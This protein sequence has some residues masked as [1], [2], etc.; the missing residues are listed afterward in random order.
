M[1][2]SMSWIICIIF[3]FVARS[4]GA[5][6]MCECNKPTWSTMAFRD[7]MESEAECRNDCGF[8]GY[9]W[10]EKHDGCIG[11]KKRTY[12]KSRESLKQHV[13]WCIFHEGCGLFAGDTRVD[14]GG[15]RNCF[16]VKETHNKEARY[17][18]SAHDD[19]VLGEVVNESVAEIKQEVVGNFHWVCDHEKQGSAMH[20]M[21]G[22]GDIGGIRSL[23]SRYQQHNPNAR[24]QLAGVPDSYVSFLVQ[25]HCPNVAPDASR[26]RER[27]DR[28][29]R[30]DRQR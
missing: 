2:K 25:Q 5:E 11:F 15:I 14:L 8:V 3:C 16:M 20:G 9:S 21:L 24:N 29:D 27:V 1:R 26:D 22:R 17:Q 6:G 30:P 7:C 4:S 23:Y 10:T 13:K 19:T 28:P 18:I 12:T